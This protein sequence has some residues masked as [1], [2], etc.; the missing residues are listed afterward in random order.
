MCVCV[1]VC[2]IIQSHNFYNKYYTFKPN[3]YYIYQ[4]MQIKSI[5][6]SVLTLL[7]PTVAAKTKE[8]QEENI[9]MTYLVFLSISVLL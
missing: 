5:F 9:T 7:V 2:V 6:T 4:N 3:I 8:D 1:C